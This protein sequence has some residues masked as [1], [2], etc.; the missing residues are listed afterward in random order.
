M[1]ARQ[2]SVGETDAHSDSSLKRLRDLGLLTFTHVYSDVGVM[3][4]HFIREKILRASCLSD[5]QAN[6][7][8]FSSEVDELPVLVH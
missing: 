2:I 8:L 6:R 4:R 3:T 1:L 7:Q 5:V